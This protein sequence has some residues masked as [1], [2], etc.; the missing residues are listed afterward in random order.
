MIDQAFC[1]K[2]VM[3]SL[4]EVHLVDLWSLLSVREGSEDLD[5]NEFGIANLNLHEEVGA[6]NNLRPDGNRVKVSEFFTRL[7]LHLMSQFCNHVELLLG[8]TR[9]LIPSTC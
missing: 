3:L 1:S 8:K 7:L 2:L 4:L 9:A 5:V 6:G